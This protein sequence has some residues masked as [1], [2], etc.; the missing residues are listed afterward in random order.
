[1]RGRAPP[2]AIA[3]ELAGKSLHSSVPP[4]DFS[5]YHFIGVGEADLRSA[6]GPPG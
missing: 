3:T 1:M 4:V 6:Q 2:A 5:F